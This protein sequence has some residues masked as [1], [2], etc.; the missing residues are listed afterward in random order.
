MKLPDSS[1]IY[2]FRDYRKRPIYIGRA[3]S[4]RSRV[5][6]YFG[7]GLEK[8]RGP[9]LIEM[10]AKSKR[11]TWQSTDSVLEAIL[12]ENILIKRYQ[13]HYNIAER[14]D[15]SSQYV[16]ITDEPWPRVFLVRAR[17][18]ERSPQNGSGQYRILKSFGPFPD[19]W[20]II[21]SLKILR[22]MFPFRDKKSNDPRH[23]HFYQ[24]LG[25]SPETDTVEARKKYMKTIRYLMMFFEGKKGALQAKIEREM[26]RYAKNL[27][28]EEAAQ[29]K[30]LLYAL[31]HINDVALIRRESDL[32]SYQ[33]KSVTDAGFRMEAYDIAHLSG[34]NVVGSMVASVNGVFAKSEYRKFKIKKETNNDALNL[35]EVVYRRLNHSEWTYP[36][37]IIVDGNEVQLE[38]VRN[39]LK[40]RRLEIP[41]VAVVKDKGHK[42][43]RILGDETIIQ[44]CHKDIIAL[45]AECHRFTI[46][47]H[48]KRR[49]VAFI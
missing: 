32:L 45:N 8:S 37:L 13:P 19:I 28:F 36:D 3:T 15:K 29:A 21:Q 10:I 22:R 26:K 46:A 9:R 6:S 14:D 31:K 18:L 41:T 1:G 47:Y 35:A 49:S 42:A 40:A 39:V 25:H 17:E 48:R 38:A 2:I 44:R 23:E 34:T 4:L 27:K 12:L 5:K 33:T 16:V 7:P 43:S 20:L 24:S 30:K 11:L